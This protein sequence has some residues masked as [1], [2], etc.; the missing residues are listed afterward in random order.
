MKNSL[1]DSLFL[2]NHRFSLR[3]YCVFWKGTIYGFLYWE[4]GGLEQLLN[5]MGFIPNLGFNIENLSFIVSRTLA[6]VHIPVYAYTCMK[7]AYAGLEH[8]YAYTSLRMHALGF[9][10]PLFYKNSFIQS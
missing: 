8:E 2:V 1:F 9:L 10:W 5:D 4:N 7:L 6:C 3:I